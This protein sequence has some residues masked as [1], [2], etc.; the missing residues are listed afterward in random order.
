[1]DTFYGPLDAL[2]AADFED[3][4]RS[5]LVTEQQLVEVRLL[6]TL[7]VTLAPR[8][9]PFAVPIVAAVVAGILHNQTTSVGPEAWH[10]LGWADP[11]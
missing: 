8:D 2:S 3:E 9:C 10:H 4:E 1:M 5:L 6:V 11:S 7:A